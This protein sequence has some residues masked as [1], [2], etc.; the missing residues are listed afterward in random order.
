MTGFAPVPDRD[1]RSAAAEA[2]RTVD[3]WM[4]MGVARAAELMPTAWEKWIGGTDVFLS[5]NLNAV[6]WSVFID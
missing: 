6:A 4:G 2:L 5:D 1:L 3:V